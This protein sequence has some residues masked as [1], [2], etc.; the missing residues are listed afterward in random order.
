MLAGLLLA[1]AAATLCWSLP[2]VV[3]DLSSTLSCDDKDVRFLLYSVNPAEGF[4]LQR[5]VRI[6]LHPL[7]VV[8]RICLIVPFWG[9]SAGLLAG[10]RARAQFAG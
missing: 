3:A 1:T 10:H 9:P 6:P 8:P 5:D 4:N 7:P 2:T